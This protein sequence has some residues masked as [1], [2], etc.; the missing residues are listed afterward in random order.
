MMQ[1]LVMGPSRYLEDY[2][3]ALIAILYFQ[4]NMV[5]FGDGLL[6]IGSC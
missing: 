3:S 1:S 2:Q 4:V 5:A 6:L